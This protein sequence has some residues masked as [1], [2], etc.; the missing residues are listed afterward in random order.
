MSRP[1]EKALTEVIPRLSGPLP[2]ELTE[3]A[4]S[5]LAQSRSKISNLKAEEEIGRTYA[6]AHIACERYRL[7]ITSLGVGFSSKQKDGDIV[8]ST[9]LEQTD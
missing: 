6:C 5:L 3:L 4:S 9:A 7:S 1:I 8:L 2:V